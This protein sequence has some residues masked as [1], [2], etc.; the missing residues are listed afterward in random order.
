MGRGTEVAFSQRR[1]TSD[2]QVQEKAL[3]VQTVR[4]MQVK[5]SVSDHL[6]PSVTVVITKTASENQCGR[7]C[8]A[9]PCALLVEM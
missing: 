4:E 6:V 1:H 5:T 2:Q 3:N 8:G 9:D 7:G